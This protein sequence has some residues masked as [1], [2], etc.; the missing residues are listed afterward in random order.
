MS[1]TRRCLFVALALTVS[2]MVA[3]ADDLLLDSRISGLE[4][5][6]SGARTRLYEA[7][8][9]SV[10]DV[11]RSE[12]RLRSLAIP[13]SA[14]GLAVD[15]LERDLIDLRHDADRLLRSRRL[16][17][18]PGSAPQSVPESYRPPYPEDIRGIERSIGV[19][20]QVVLVQRSLRNT[21]RELAAARNALAVRHLA[22]AEGDLARLAH[23]G[24]DPTLDALRLEATR[25]RARLAAP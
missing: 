14:S 12:A 15:R 4:R 20:K 3:A 25:L 2:P 11:R 24:G 6:L 17:R 18:R 16:G 1:M 8:R 7:P 21:S 5:G 23:L 19:G 10:Y 13:P 9:R 22:R